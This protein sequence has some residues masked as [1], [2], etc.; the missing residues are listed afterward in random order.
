MTCAIAP[1]SC[2]LW[3][4][5]LRRE[6]HGLRWGERQRKPD[7]HGEVGVKRDPLKTPGAQRGEAVFVLQP[8]ELALDSRATPVEVTPPLRLARDERVQAA[9]LDPDRGGL[10]FP[11]GAPCGPRVSRDP[12]SSALLAL[13]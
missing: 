7:E 4:A 9:R 13:Q 1:D 10:A 2:A 11:G 3:S 6:G 12:P 8:A 5:A